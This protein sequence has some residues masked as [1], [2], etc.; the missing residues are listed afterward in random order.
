VGVAA[1][2][3]PPL[4]SRA[5]ALT[6]LRPCALPPAQITF[7]G[8]RMRKPVVRKT[9]DYNAAVMNHLQVPS[10]SWPAQLPSLWWPADHTRGR[11]TASTS[12]TGATSATCSRPSIT[13]KTWVAARGQPS[14]AAAAHT[15]TLLHSSTWWWQ[16]RTFQ[17]WASAPRSAA[18]LARPGPR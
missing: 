6:A 12:A 15:D 1:R 13:S 8:K 5:R 9:V 11:R 2:T 14:F 10:A 18:A 7:D 17:P 3:C 4:P 16:H